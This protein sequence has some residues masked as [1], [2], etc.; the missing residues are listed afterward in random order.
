MLSCI[1]S[2]K[3]LFLEGGYEIIHTGFIF[4]NKDGLC[5]SATPVHWLIVA[6]L[7]YRTAKI[8]MNAAGITGQKNDGQ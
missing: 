8:K 1:Q 3:N 7:V 5:E 6:E 4:S 2:N